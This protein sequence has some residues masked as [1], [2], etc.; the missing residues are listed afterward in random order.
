MDEVC[1][2]KSHVSHGGSCE[3]GLEVRP[4]TPIQDFH[5][6][7]ETMQIILGFISRRLTMTDNV[8]GLQQGNTNRG[9]EGNPV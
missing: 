3:N 7:G 6:F 1:F 5:M 2:L 9:G 4:L 8:S